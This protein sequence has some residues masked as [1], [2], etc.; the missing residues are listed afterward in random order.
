M[1]IYLF[2][3]GSESN[4]SLVWLPDKV[5]HLQ[6]SQNLYQVVKCHLVSVNYHKQTHFAIT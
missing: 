2:S 3:S 6:Q 5:H 4:V 1:G